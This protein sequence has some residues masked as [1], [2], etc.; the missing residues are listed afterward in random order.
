M[1]PPARPTGSCGS[2]V[3]A[4]DFDDTL[5][6][7]DSLLPFLSLA[8]GRARVARAV[9]VLGPRFAAAMIG[10][11]GRDAVKAA[12]IGRL[13][14]GFP[15]ASL[16]DSGQAYARTLA[17]RLRPDMVER[18]EWHRGQGHRLIVVSASLTVYLEPLAALCG[19][20]RVLATNLE[21]GTDGL[22]TG[23]LLGAN[24][25]G[26]EKVVRLSEWLA[27]DPCRIWAYGNRGGDRFL[28]SA[29]D[30]GHLVRRRRVTDW[31]TGRPARNGGPAAVP[32]GTASVPPHAPE[33]GRRPV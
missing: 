10:A 8:V 31:N 12:L 32:K 26:R 13:L 17:G 23:R 25:R 20:D 3:A 30:H 28:L 7:G 15:A 4:F 1:E 19:F 22:L 5:I 33:R 16:A 27:G 24:V 6:R 9:T 29:A 2:D 14:R 11:G 18:V 21:V